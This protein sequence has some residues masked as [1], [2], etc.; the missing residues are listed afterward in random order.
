VNTPARPAIIF[1]AAALLRRLCVD[2]YRPD[3]R[4]L[5]G[6]TLCLAG[7]ALIMM[8]GYGRIGRRTVVGFYF[9]K[10]YRP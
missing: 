6:G 9:A 7:V 5:L 3:R 8:H 2:G 1:V 4:D 10:P